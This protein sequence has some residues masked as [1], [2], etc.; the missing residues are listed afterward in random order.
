MSN[1]EYQKEYR[2]KNK[3]RLNTY[4]EK[5]KEKIKKVRKEYYQKNKE[6][7]KKE[8]I[9]YYENNRENR[10][11]YQNLRYKK[12]SK[13]INQKYEPYRK[14]YNRLKKN[15]RQTLQFRLNERKITPTSKELQ[16]MEEMTKW[17]CYKNH[18]D[19]DEMIG[20][21]YT[22]LLIGLR[23][24]DPKKLKNTTKEIY[25][26]NNI[27]TE[28][29]GAYWYRKKQTLKGKTE[30]MLSGI[31]TE[32]E[33]KSII[34]IIPGK[35]DHELDVDIK[36]EVKY[37]S[38][39]IKEGFIKSVKHRKVKYPGKMLYNIWYDKNVKDMTPAELQKK[40]NMSYRQMD[41]LLTYIRKK[42]EKI[43]EE[44]LKSNPSWF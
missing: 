6:K 7:I 19:Y 12:N 41:C 24:Y 31:T 20:S 36:D 26:K 43:Q 38:K 11:E 37:F 30:I 3:D 27:R 1:K 5:N 34:N 23:L 39:I 33:E 25:V 22:G 35:E 13:E 40:Y 21:G 10:K 44:I 29:G 16:W 4:R 2:K 18:L 14:A 8:R 15:T 17:F 42:F 9:E 28:L 32:N